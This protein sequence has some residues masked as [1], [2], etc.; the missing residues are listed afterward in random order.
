[1][2]TRGFMVIMLLTEHVSYYLL[3]LNMTFEQALYLL[4]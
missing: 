1:V 4:P 3:F 2:F